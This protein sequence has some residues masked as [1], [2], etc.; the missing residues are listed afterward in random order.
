MA[1]KDPAE[2]SELSRMA[3]LTRWANTPDRTAAAQASR[4]A[5]MA[6][7]DPGPEV[8]EPQRSAMIRAGLEAHMIRMR[9]ARRNRQR[10]A[11][12][13]AAAELAELAD[14]GEAS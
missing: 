14:D 13:A 6:R 1:A 11:A 7:F 5:L 10:E 9:R 12:E 2:R 4:D 8:P 3:V